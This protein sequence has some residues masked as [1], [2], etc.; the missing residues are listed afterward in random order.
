[1]VNICWFKVYNYDRGGREF[2]EIIRRKYK[3]L[4]YFVWFEDKCPHGHK[5]LNDTLEIA[6][7]K[8]NKKKVGVNNFPK[9]FFNYKQI[10]TWTLHHHDGIGPSPVDVKAISC[11]TPSPKVGNVLSKWVVVWRHEFS[12]IF[13]TFE[14]FYIFLMSSQMLEL[15]KHI[16]VVVVFYFFPNMRWKLKVYL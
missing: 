3:K 5:S 16:V 2:L 11:L 15:Y 9:K 4:A 13:Y 7:K 1:M 12:K 6:I 8:N 14:A 10:F